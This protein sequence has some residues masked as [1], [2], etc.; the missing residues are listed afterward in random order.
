MSRFGRASKWIGASS[1]LLRGSLA[2]LAVSGPALAT[3]W[4]LKFGA[5][6]SLTADDNLDLTEFDRDA[7]L[8]S[9]T[10][11][12]LNLLG[13]GKTYKMGLAPRVSIGRTFFSEAPDD[14]SYSPAGTLSLG[15]WT[16]LTTYDLVASVARSEASSSNALVEDDVITTD[17]GDAL[18]YAVT[19]TITHKVNRRNTLSWANSANRLDYTLPCDDTVWMA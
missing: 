15:T 10:A 8:T 18:T 5:S 14:W 9:S 7:G 11:F 13:L 4:S 6:Q 19:G 2:A 12:D 17:E 3:D 1:W 16:K